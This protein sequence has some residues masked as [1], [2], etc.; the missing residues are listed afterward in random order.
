[1]DFTKCPG[2]SAFG[3]SVEGCRGNFDF[4]L[5][6]ERIFLSLVPASAFIALALARIAFLIRRSTVVDNLTLMSLKLV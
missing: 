6:F 5:K 1:M 2:D 4:T 3:P